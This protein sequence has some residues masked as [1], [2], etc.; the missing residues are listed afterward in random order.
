MISDTQWNLVEAG[1]FGIA[2]GL[3]IVLIFAFRRPRSWWWRVP[4]VVFIS[5]VSL[6]LYTTEVYCRIGI[7]R[8]EQHGAENP[9]EGFDNNNVA[10]VI[11]MGWLAP[12][13]TIG[14]I[15]AGRRFLFRYVQ[16]RHTNA[17]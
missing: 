2:F 4:L 5:W 7:A 8:A 14:I 1:A 16:Q 17:A 3:P 10:P 11:L 13:L 15:A 6:V 9:G 12:A